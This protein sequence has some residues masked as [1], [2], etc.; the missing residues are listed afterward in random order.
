[1]KTA[2]WERTPQIALKNCSK[3]VAGERQY[4]HDFGEGGYM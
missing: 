1:M 2:A 4:T 3:E